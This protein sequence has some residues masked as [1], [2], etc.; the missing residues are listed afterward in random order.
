M[1][2]WKKIK[3]WLGDLSFKFMGWE[4]KVDISKKPTH[5]TL[6]DAK[7][8]TDNS[9]SNIGKV[10]VE[11]KTAAARPIPGQEVVDPAQV[12]DARDAT[13]QNKGVKSI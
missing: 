1:N 4:N 3:D 5:T 7:F 11:N 8:Y 2:L 10:N 9:I 6:G 12:P 13:T